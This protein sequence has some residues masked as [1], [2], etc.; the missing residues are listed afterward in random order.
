M[1]A[2]IARQELHTGFGECAALD[3]AL[4]RA[5]ECSRGRQTYTSQNIH[6]I[7]KPDKHENRCKASEEAKWVVIRMLY[8]RRAESRQAR[9][10]LGIIVA[11]LAAKLRR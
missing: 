3:L 9:R 2:G 6:H 5:R 8:R 4:Q 1:V 10:G 11:A 7:C